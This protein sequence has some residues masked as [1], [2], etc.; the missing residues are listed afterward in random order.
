MDLGIKQRIALISGGDSGMG[1]ET[2]RQ[3]LEAGVRVAMPFLP[4][5][6]SSGGGLCCSRPK[7]QCSRTWMS[8]P[9]ARP[10]PAS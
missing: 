4:C 5:V 8:W 3:L 6:A 7:M 10:R 9:T 2:A 1:K